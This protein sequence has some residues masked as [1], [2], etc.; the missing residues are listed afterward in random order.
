MNA[1]KHVI[2]AQSQK[3]QALPAVMIGSAP[4]ASMKCPS[5]GGLEPQATP[6]MVQIWKRRQRRR[7]PD[8]TTGFTP[9]G[10]P[11][12]GNYGTRQRSTLGYDLGREPINLPGGRL[13]RVRYAPDSGPNSAAQRNDAMC[14]IQ[15]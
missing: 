5:C 2:R 11:R 1:A 14:Q 15:T 12:F 9:G 8:R 10:N 13:A 4:F 3:A 7:R 6:I